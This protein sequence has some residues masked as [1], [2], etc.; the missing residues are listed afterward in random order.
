MDRAN[1][2]ACG[3]SGVRATK[4][5]NEASAADCTPEPQTK[6]VCN[7]GSGWR[8]RNDPPGTDKA[9]DAR[10]AECSYFGWHRPEDACGQNEA[11]ATVYVKS[12]RHWR[13]IKLTVTFATTVASL[14]NAISESLNGFPVEEM[15]LKSRGG[16]V[17]KDPCSLR[18]AA[19]PGWECAICLFL[20]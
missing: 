18:E 13:S 1:V 5:A 16:R 6:R 17:L 8:G 10:H 15:V 7:D 3:G 9:E 11:E 20:E 19:F 12:V 4:R 14:K 2:E